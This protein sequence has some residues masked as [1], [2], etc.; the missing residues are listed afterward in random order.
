MRRAVAQG[1][2]AAVEVEVGIEVVGDLQAGLFEAGKRA[3]VRQQFGFERAPAGLG[4]RVIIGV[5]RPAIASQRLSLF[6]ARPASQTG[7]LTAAV[8]MDNQAGSRLAQRQRLF[9]GHEH[10]FSGHLLVEVPAD[11]APRTGIAPG[12]QITPAPAD[13]G[14]VRDVAH[15]HL[16]GRSRGRLTKQEIFGHDRCGVSDRRAWALGSRAQRPQAA[17]A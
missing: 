14:Q 5:A 12:G 2:V 3:A 7:I 17:A 11:N 10:Q 8:G 6:D 13:K 15:P 9:Q 16:I 4:L 1:R